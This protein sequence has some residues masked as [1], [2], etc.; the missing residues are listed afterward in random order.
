MIAVE[1]PVE[2]RCKDIKVLLTQINIYIMAMQTWTIAINKDIKAEII[3]SIV[4]IIVSIF[5]I[6]TMIAIDSP[7]RKSAIWRK[8]QL[9]RPPQ[10][11]QGCHT[12]SSSSH[13][14]DLRFCKPNS[15]IYQYSDNLYNAFQTTKLHLRQKDNW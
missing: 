12:K 8:D 13:Q 9:H 11:R 2:S 15:I 14:L 1:W 6:T 4:I 3:I 7:G 5:E 10:R